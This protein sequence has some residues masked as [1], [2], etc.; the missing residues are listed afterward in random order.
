MK[1]VEHFEHPILIVIT[2]RPGSGKTTLA[3]TLAR[4][5]RC[6]IISR[7]EI[8]EGLVNTLK[9]S[10]IL[11]EADLNGDVYNTFFETIEFLLR[12]N[13]TLVSEAAFQHKLWTPKL[14]SLKKIAQIK[15]ICCS[16]NSQLAKSRFI[17]RGL[18][19]P[20]RAYFHDDWSIQKT[21][22]GT[23][24]LNSSYEPPKLSVPTLIVDTS[25]N[26]Q[27]IFEEIVAF[28]NDPV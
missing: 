28:V 18:E 13:I 12:K 21:K 23:D 1:K 3:R 27:P 11:F 8:K 14:N 25:E 22:E 9:N 19:D 16:V 7:D 24:P 10:E 17:Q 6:P 4:T 15:L 5:I 2:G 26:Y 20:E